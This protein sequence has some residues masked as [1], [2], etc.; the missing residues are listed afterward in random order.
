MQGTLNIPKSNLRISTI[1]TKRKRQGLYFSQIN[2][3]ISDVN[4]LQ[5]AKKMLVIGNQL[6]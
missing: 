4:Y 3:S 5:T 6:E 2:E 1:S